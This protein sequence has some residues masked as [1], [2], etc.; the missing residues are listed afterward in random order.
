M[1]GRRMRAGVAVFPY[2]NTEEEYPSDVR[3]WLDIHN[4]G[5]VDAVRE[6]DTPRNRAVLAL[7][8]LDA[9]YSGIHWDS[10]PWRD[11]SL[12][13]WC[14]AWYVMHAIARIDYLVSTGHM[15]LGF[16]P[17]KPDDDRSPGHQLYREW[18]GMPG[19]DAAEKEWHP[20]NRAVKA[21]WERLAERIWGTA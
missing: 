12:G 9:E 21:R 14:Q 6:E 5:P 3:E 8:R 18:I 7:A 2:R 16:L 1:S 13:S 11:E 20:M 17:R 19:T 4:G 15:T 10:I